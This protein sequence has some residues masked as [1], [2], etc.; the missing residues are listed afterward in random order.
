M[1]GWDTN[2]PLFDRLPLAYRQ[3]EP[4]EW[5]TGAWDELLV[6]AKV[7]GDNFYTNFLDPENC[8]VE[9]LDW[10]AQLAGFTGEYW[11]PLWSETVKRSLIKNS[12]DLIWPQK[13][14]RDLLEWILAELGLQAKVYL[15]GDFLLNVTPLGSPLGSTK[16]FEYFIRT[17]LAYLRT[18]P[19]WLLAE[20]LNRL[21]GPVYCKSRVCYDQFYLTYSVLGDPL[22][23][24]PVF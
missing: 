7:S 9:V 21:Y 18:N 24:N 6:T 19:D 15:L 20:K 13:G 22:F 4:V 5:F 2:K 17:P 3:C 11:D 10:L 1:A 12:Y 14:S 16:G 23:D 8:K